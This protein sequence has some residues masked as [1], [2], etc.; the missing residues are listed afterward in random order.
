MFFLS[1]ARV[2]P[3]Q[4]DGIACRQVTGLAISGSR[5][6]IRRAPAARGAHHG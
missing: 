3:N 6:I 5:V 2:L 1:M 4:P